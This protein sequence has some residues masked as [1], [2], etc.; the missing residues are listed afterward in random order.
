[1]PK[2]IKIY[3]FEYIFK[4]EIKPPALSAIG[5]NPL[6]LRTK[7]PEVNIP[8]VATAVPKIPPINSPCL[9]FIPENFP[10]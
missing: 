2:L 8:I 4:F 7:T 5:P 6:M 9:S 10:K 3:Y 1:M